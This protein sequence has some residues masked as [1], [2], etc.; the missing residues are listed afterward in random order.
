MAQARPGLGAAGDPLPP[1]HVCYETLFAVHCRGLN[2]ARA[3]LHLLSFARRLETS[4]ERAPWSLAQMARAYCLAAHALA[5]ARRQPCVFLGG[6]SAR[7]LAPPRP[8]LT[9]PSAERTRPDA[10]AP[11]VANGSVLIDVAAARRLSALRSA[12]LRLARVRC[13]NHAGGWTALAR[14]PS[15]SPPPPPAAGAVAR[16]GRGSRRR[17]GDRHGV[18]RVGALWRGGDA[19]ARVGTAAAAAVRVFGAPRRGGRARH[20]GR[21]GL[22]A[23]PRHLCL[24]AAAPRTRARRVLR[25][26]AAALRRTGRA[27]GPDA[28]LCGAD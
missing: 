26:L 7:V 10:A 17:R 1:A 12:Q 23:H 16:G 21:P 25:R 14:V 2:F 13:V 24:V 18:K 20:R 22:P 15:A 19:A 3:A 27:R 4:A 28:A 6:A 5:L 11:G 8:A 9:V